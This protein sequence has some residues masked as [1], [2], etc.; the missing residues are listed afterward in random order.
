MLRGTWR[1]SRPF[2]IYVFA[3]SSNTS[4]LYFTRR[5]AETITRIGG[6]HPVRTLALTRSFVR[7]SAD[8]PLCSSRSLSNFQSQNYSSR[9]L[10][11]FGIQI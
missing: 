6:R 10:R 1:A 5:N 11:L 9:Y 2:T 4:H 8:L 7:A 3:C